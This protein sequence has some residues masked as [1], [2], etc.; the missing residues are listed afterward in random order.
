ASQPTASA[1][2]ATEASAPSARPCLLVPQTI[3]DPLLRS[4]GAPRTADRPAHTAPPTHE[5]R[6][7][8]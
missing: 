4:R 6:S 2:A 8:P 5:T 7:A 1:S 3:T